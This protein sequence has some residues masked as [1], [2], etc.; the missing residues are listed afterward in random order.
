MMNK[1]LSMGSLLSWVL[2]TILFVLGVL[3]LVFVHPVPGA[4]Y[5]LLAFLYAPPVNVLFQSRLGF[6]IPLALKLILFVP[7]LMFTLGVS[8]L[9]DLL[10]DWF[11]NA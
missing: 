5:L 2:A 6:S 4:V 9:G 7:I 1:T 10:D 8:D 11:L 3:N